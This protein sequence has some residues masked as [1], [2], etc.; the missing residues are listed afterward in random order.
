MFLMLAKVAVDQGLRDYL[1]Y[2]LGAC[3]ENILANIPKDS[4][5]GTVPGLCRQLCAM[6]EHHHNRWHLCSLLPIGSGTCQTRRCLAFLALHEVLELP[7]P[8]Q[9]MPKDVKMQH[10]LWLVGRLGGLEGAL[11]PLYSAVHLLE[12]C[13][14]RKPPPSPPWSRSAPPCCPSAGASASLGAIWTQ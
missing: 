13:V 2:Q 8:F 10:W 4:F 7:E 12:C 5:K 3:L 1:E 11:Y 14:P 9:D 6:V